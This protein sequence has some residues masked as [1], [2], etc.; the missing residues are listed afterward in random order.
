MKQNDSSCNETLPEGLI[1]RRRWR[2]Q[3]GIS[4]TTLWRWQKRGW[5]TSINIGGTAYLRTQDIAEFMTR[6]A[7]GEFTDA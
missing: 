4:D 6:A 3:V 2:Q 1:V 5:L 7:A